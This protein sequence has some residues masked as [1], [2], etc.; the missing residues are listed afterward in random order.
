MQLLD[1]QLILSATDL[2][3][4]LECEHL[5]QLELGAAHGELRAPEI[6]DPEAEVL[7]HRGAQHEQ[8]YLEHLKAE[9]RDVVGI[10][11]TGGDALSRHVE[12]HDQTLAAMRRG[13]D[14]IYQGTFFGG[15]WLG[16]AD[17]LLRVGRP[18]SLGTWSY[19]VADTKLARS[20][21]VGALLQMCAY[22]EQLAGVQGIDPEHM[23]VV[24]GD[25]SVESHRVAEYAAYYRSVKQRFLAAIG[26][27]RGDTYPEPVAHCGVC[28]W[29][30]CC[31][32]RRRADDHLSLV[33]GLRRDQT[34]KLTV[35]GVPTLAVLAASEDL[36][37]LKGIGDHTLARLRQQAR[38]QL[39]QR[40]TE[41]VHYE[42]LPPDGPGRG[43]CALPAPSPGDL[44]FDMEG[45][46]W[47]GDDGLEYLFGLVDLEGREP[48]YRAFWAHDAAAEKRAFEDFIDYVMARLADY[49]DLHIYHYASYEPDRMKRLMGRYGTREEEVDQLLRGGVFV[50]LYQVVRQGVR[51]SQESYSL[52]KLEPLYMPAR[53]TA[54]TEGGSSIVFY[55]RWIESHQSAILQDIEDYNRD[56]CISTWKLRDWLEERRTEAAGS[57]GQELPRPAPRS[58]EPVEKLHEEETRVAGLAAALTA[59]MPD[60][61]AE[62]SPEQHGRWLLAQLLGWHRREDR[63]EWWAYYER[64]RKT[65][66]ELLDDPDSIGGLSYEGVVETV[67]RS[68]VHRYRF[69]PEQEH[70][71]S[72]GATPYDPRTEA[73]AGIVVAVDNMAGTIDLKRGAASKAPH[74]TSLVPPPPI[75]NTVLRDGIARC[76][77]WLAEYGLDNAGPYQ[78][79]AGLLLRRPPRLTGEISGAPLQQAGESA[80]DAARRLALS[81]DG[82]VLPVQGPPGSGKTHTAARMILD[83]IAAG[84]RLGVTSNSHKAIGNLLEELLRA[85]R[86]EGRTIRVLQKVNE[87]EPCD[88]GVDCTNSNADVEAALA[89]GSVDVVAGTAWLFAREALSEAFD[90]LFVDEA[91]QVSLANVVA[92]SGCA[93]NLV[94]L[95]DPQQLSQVTKGTHPKGAEQ[96]ALGHLLAGHATMRP[97]LGLFLGTTWRLHPDVCRFVSEISYEGR[98]DPDPSCARQSLD[99]RTG[100]RHYSV[101]HRHNR[102]SSPEEVAQVKTLFHEMLSSHWTAAGGQSRPMT[103]EDVLVVAPYNAQVAR[104]GQS[105][106]AGARVGTVDK[107]QGQEAPVVIYS[108]A[109]SSADDLPR[110]LEFLYSLNRLNVA[111]SRARGVA[112]LVCSPA[113]LAV[114]CRTPQQMRLANALCRF[115]ELAG[116]KLFQAAAVAAAIPQA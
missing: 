3:H 87:G 88:A 98:L 112:I 78:A 85:A 115:V 36:A 23:H 76:A 84:K 26:Q 32:E 47:E 2:V 75:N 72:A 41:Q 44:F 74:P 30:T 94:L 21:K 18:S 68:L 54:I 27:P 109:T 79:A 113:L 65:D 81:L 89:A 67:K 63:P 52:K 58:M 83:L 90:T 33:A 55:E 106:P 19:E 104:L 101:E 60:D 13:A 24:L 4:F 35:A 8:R 99:G 93:R 103:L 20:V 31:E 14:V 110:N 9:G 37:A 69:N 61:P 92:M 6:E 116:A 29:N 45:D 114:R 5:T 15:G 66:D 82:T 12:E 108:L 1:N 64:L 25:M 51:V 80:Q 73:P 86:S 40:E 105:L 77:T 48:R 22:S 71:F 17:F 100:L 28:N 96:S 62:R 91:G 102:S 42:L 70:K 95:G 10:R 97:E 11:S 111:I 56:D 7:R 16:H 107:F 46:P 57:F 49:P 38:L 50:D 39:R 53:E 34:R 43:L 59:G